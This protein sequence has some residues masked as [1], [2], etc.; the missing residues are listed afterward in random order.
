MSD[1]L[2]GCRVLFTIDEIEQVGVLVK[3]DRSK[4][5]YLM[6]W[7]LRPDGSILEKY[8]SS[9]TIHPDDVKFIT[10][11][12]TSYKLREKILTDNTDRFEILDL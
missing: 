12:S 4:S 9:L 6:A 5:S 2:V 3:I 11:L 1:L 7:V 10:G 8:M